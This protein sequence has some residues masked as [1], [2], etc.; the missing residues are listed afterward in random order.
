MSD[1]ANSTLAGVDAAS[2]LYQQHA[3]IRKAPRASLKT[4]TALIVQ[5]R[6]ITKKQLEKFYCLRGKRFD[7]VAFAKNQK[8]SL[9]WLI[10]GTLALHPRV[11]APPRE[12][13]LARQKTA[14]TVEEFLRLVAQL[15]PEDQPAIL[16]RMRQLA[17]RV[18]S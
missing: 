10:D 8:V 13:K 5:Q 6:G 4:R 11:P 14:P 12:K 18:T 15:P 7:Y 2:R 9:D 16:A 3:N 1:D 17:N